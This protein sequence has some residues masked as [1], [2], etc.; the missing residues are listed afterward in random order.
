MH[1]QKNCAGPWLQ[2]A[3][4]R[5]F[6]HDTQL[7]MKRHITNISAKNAISSNLLNIDL[8][9]APLCGVDR[10]KGPTI[11]LEHYSTTELTNKLNDVLSCHEHL[12][13]TGLIPYD[14]QPIIH[15]NICYD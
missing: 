15:L 9:N 2:P 5:H 13:A 11:N 12:K 3:H 4:S 7:K 8:D 14:K 1:P 10:L 6:E